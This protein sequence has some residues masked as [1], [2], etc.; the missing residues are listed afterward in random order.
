METLNT[1]DE[2]ALWTSTVAATIG[3][4]SY[5]D[6]DIVARFADRMV[7]E[8]RKRI[9][10]AGLSGEPDVKSEPYPPGLDAR[11]QAAQNAGKHVL[12]TFGN[13]DVSKGTVTRKGDSYWQLSTDEEFGTDHGFSPEE[14]AVKVEILELEPADLNERLRLAAEQGQ[15]VRVQFADGGDPVEGHV[16]WRPDFADDTMPA[17]VGSEWCG[18]TERDPEYRAIS[19]EILDA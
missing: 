11:L 14:R 13:G 16:I 5:P 7:L 15:R 1:P 4:A 8:L 19:V 10:A 18:A 9:P 3:C 2:I 6:P 17:R 12:V